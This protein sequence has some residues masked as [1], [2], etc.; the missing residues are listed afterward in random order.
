MIEPL[1]S[2]ATLACPLFNGMSREEIDKLIENF[3]HRIIS[4]GKKDIFAMEGDQCKNADIVLEGELTAR[5]TS[6]SGKFVQVTKLLPGDILAPAYIFAMRN[7]MP[8]EVEADKE[9]KI[10][11][12]PSESFAKIIDTHDKV[13][14]NFIRLISNLNGFLTAKIRFLSLMTV[15]EK[16]CS[17]LLE[18]RK[19]QG[20]DSIV[21]RKS[22]QEIA[23]AFGIQKF[24][25]MRCLAELQEE[26][27]ISLDGKSV[28]IL[29]PDLMKS[30]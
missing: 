25:V 26:G 9:T 1:H 10:L 29:R 23:D 7:F 13:R 2:D 5:M 6:P 8:V 3:E 12:I 16:I 19:Q 22:R 20:S 27:I 15:R 11:R 18:L 24:S 28:N 17:M 30:L 21:L 14:W 4:V